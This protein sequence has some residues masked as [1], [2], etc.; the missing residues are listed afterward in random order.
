MASVHS[1]VENTV[2]S[3][4]QSVSQQELWTGATFK[5]WLEPLQQGTEHSSRSPL[6]Q[7][8]TQS[9]WP[10]HLW[11]LVSEEFVLETLIGTCRCTAFL[12]IHPTHLGSV[13]WDLLKDYCLCV[14][15]MKRNL[16]ALQYIV[17]TGNI[18]FN[19]L[20]VQEKHQIITRVPFWLLSKLQMQAT[21]LPRGSLLKDVR[22]FVSSVMG[23][24]A[25][26]LWF[27]DRLAPLAYIYGCREPASQ[28]V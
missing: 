26:W 1:C 5:W 4:F 3:C 14:I 10:Q 7:A 19:S 16:K 9:W 2:P 24:V 11:S 12:G 27:R 22:H 13:N 23:T 20:A 28:E 8:T 17:C 21:T 25:A 18:N 6:T 15:K